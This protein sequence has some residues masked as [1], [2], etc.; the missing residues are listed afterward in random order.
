MASPGAVR[1]LMLLAADRPEAADLIIAAREPCGRLRESEPHA[2]HECGPVRDQP[3][4]FALRVC[5][6]R[7]GATA[8]IDRPEPFIAAVRLCVCIKLRCILLFT[9]T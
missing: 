1:T 9:V 6:R 5:H 4:G 7:T 3:I 8:G 2:C